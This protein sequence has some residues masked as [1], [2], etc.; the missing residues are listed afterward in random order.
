VRAL[1]LVVAID[2]AILVAC[3]GPSSRAPATPPT[4]DEV[5]A[6]TRA[7][8]TAAAHWARR[9]DEAE[10]RAAIADWTVAAHARPDDVAVAES[11]ARAH[12]FLAEGHLVFRK[13]TDAAAADGYV[14]AL[15]A[16]AVAAETA[17][18]ARWPAF[19]EKR[20]LDVPFE[21]AFVLLDDG[22]APLLYW[23][24][25]CRM[26]AAN[27]RGLGAT[28]TTHQA[29][30]TVMGRVAAIAPD[31]WYGAADR[32]FG[33]VYAAA[34]AIAGGDLT[35]SRAHFAAARARAPGFLESRLLYGLFLE[36][37]AE[38]A[39]V[40]RGDG[41]DDDPAIAPEQDVARRKAGM[42]L[43]APARR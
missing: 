27:A 29:V 11:L 6:A 32:Y 26:L 18:R 16:G 36:D 4:A 12:H 15:D 31:Y 25:Q 22:A 8:D 9:A 37:R 35:K 10:L 24:S 34:P 33:V 23:W 42:L 17:L 14:A 13:D 40:A 5:A 7:R 1:V 41:A 30:F 38:L 19:G 20:A 21:E 3:A 28:I 43:A 2:A 39:A